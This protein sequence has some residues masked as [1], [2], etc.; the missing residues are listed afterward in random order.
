MACSSSLACEPPF[1]PVTSTSVMAVASGYGKLAV[2]LA[3]EVAAQ[4]DQ[5]EHAEAAAG[6]ADED[7][8]HRMRIELEDVERGQREDGAGHD[9]AGDAADAG[10]DDVLEQRG[11][12]RVD[13]RE[14]DGED[15]DG[16]GRFHHLPDLQARVGGGDGEDDAQQAGP[17]RPIAV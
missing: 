3:D 7:R 5:E 16:D 6:Q 9:R 12:A 15:R 17:S 14:A 4:R 8:L 1:S 10:D 2:H 11:T 13:A